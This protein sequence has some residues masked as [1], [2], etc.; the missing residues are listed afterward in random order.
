MDGS[1]WFS[2]Y[3]GIPCSRVLVLSRGSNFRTFDAERNRTKL[4]KKLTANY[5]KM[6]FGAGDVGGEM[7][8]FRVNLTFEMFRFRAFWVVKLL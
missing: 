2:R 5:R 6:G 1:G 7:F 4:P 8:R 3:R